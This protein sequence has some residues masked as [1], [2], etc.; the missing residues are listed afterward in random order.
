MTANGSFPWIADL[1]QEQDLGEIEFVQAIFIDNSGN[2][3]GLVITVDSG[4]VI[5]C[6]ANAQCCKPVFSFT[7][8]FTVTTATGA[9]GQNKQTG[10]WLSNMPLPAFGA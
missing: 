2:N 10:I 6:A 5:T 9:A 1:S 8:R 4:Q 7:P 3:V